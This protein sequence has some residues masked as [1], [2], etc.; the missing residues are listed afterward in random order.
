M[1]SVAVTGG[2]GYVGGRI[3][4][5]LLA[6]GWDVRVA[7]RR[8]AEQIPDWARGRVLWGHDLSI[9][10][11]GADSIL[12]LAAPNET[13]AA[14][15]P[16]CAIRETVDLTRLALEAARKTGVG[17]FIYFS[18]VHVYG[19]LAG[20]IT[21]ATPAQPTHP[22]AIGHHQSEQLVQAAADTRMGALI[23]R[24]SN[25]FGAP[26]DAGAERWSLLVNDL[27][28]QAVCEGSLTL[29]SS[30][31]Q[32]R[33]FIPLHDV[34]LATKYFLERPKPAS[35]SDILNLSSGKSMT[36]RQMA[37]LILERARLLIRPD[38][39]LSVA[40]SDAKP[41]MPPLVISN[42]HLIQTGFRLSADFGTEVDELLAF[43]K[44]TFP[45]GS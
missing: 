8:G 30:G 40:E 42:Q 35:A 36:V 3:V 21:E 9:L 25:S 13:I 28:R 37:E 15:D 31:L 7:T 1:K 5:K 17:R 24:L 16:D 19:P 22:Y 29:S 2:F 6:D 14:R 11:E 23:V 45:P 33:D 27:C 39:Q 10:A 34:L 18:T 20:T 12:H 38:M 4:Q 32:W 44:S 26:A 41:V 43:C